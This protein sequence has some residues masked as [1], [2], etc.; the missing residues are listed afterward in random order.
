MIS[1]LYLT[2]SA[3]TETRTLNQG[4]LLKHNTLV[5]PLQEGLPSTLLG[6]LGSV[7]LR[8]R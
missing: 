8:N 6:R 1:Q 4:Y 3:D 7:K 5:V 2:I